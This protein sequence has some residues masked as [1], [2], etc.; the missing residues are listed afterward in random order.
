MSV[1]LKTERF[2]ILSGSNRFTVST[3]LTAVPTSVEPSGSLIRGT[4]GTLWRSHGGG[5]W[6]Q[7]GLYGHVMRDVPTTSSSGFTTWLNQ[8]AG[9][10]VTNGTQGMT[11][12]SPSN[13]M[14]LGLM[15]Q[16][17]PSTPYTIVALLACTHD[18]GTDSGIIFGWSDGT[19]VL[20]LTIEPSPPQTNPTFGIRTIQFTNVNTYLGAPTSQNV[21]S[22]NPMWVRLRDDGT[23]ASFA[24]SPTGDSDQWLVIYSVTKAGSFL[25]T[26]GYSNVVLGTS[27]YSGQ[28]YVKLMSW[29]VTTP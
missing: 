7:L 25:G 15:K 2:Q 17:S 4:D 29:Q 8:P 11:I 13:G 14:N 18:P 28:S 3:S 20:G 19:K 21:L 6:G 12:Y 22:Y 1:D 9:N 10:T 23:T 27:S 5:N 26:T 24:V 16:S